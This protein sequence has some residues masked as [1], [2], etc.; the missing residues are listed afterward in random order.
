LTQH[1]SREF[2]EITMGWSGDNADDLEARIQLA[3]ERC[4]KNPEGIPTLA[5]DRVLSA[6]RK[7]L[8]SYR[9]G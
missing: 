8:T 1:R 6:M 3:T 9:G 4:A 7:A 2:D 5:E